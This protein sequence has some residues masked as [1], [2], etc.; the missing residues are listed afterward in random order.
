MKNFGR[1]LL[2]LTL[3]LV[4]MSQAAMAQD[5]RSVILPAPYTSRVGTQLMYVY[6]DGVNLGARG[7]FKTFM[8]IVNTNITTGVYVH[9]QF[10]T[11]NQ[12]TTGCVE[13]FDFVDY[14]TP[15]QRHIFDPR[16]VKGTWDLSTQV[17]VATDGRFVMTATPISVGRAWA[18]SPAD[19]RAVAFNHLSGQLWVSDVKKQA[20]YMTNAISRMAVDSLGTPLPTVAGGIILNGEANW[21]QM[22]RP[23]ILSVN[24]FFR[25]QGANAVQA[26]VPFGNRMTLFAWSD[27]YTNAQQMYRILTARVT[28][29]AFVFDDAEN[30][31]SVPPR[32][33]NCVYDYV[34]APDVAGASG[35][36]PDFLGAALTSAVANTGGWLRMRTVLGDTHNIV[37][38]FSQYLG[39]FGGGDYL[40]GE[41]RTP[42]KVD[43]AKTPSPI[44]GFLTINTSTGD[45]SGTSY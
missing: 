45:V 8:T 33:I 29:N 12:S 1:A 15:G 4:L 37:G 30:A 22:F 20:T 10:Y 13:L 35:N 31:F 27:Q 3:G 21:L 19:L 16:A 40:I 11:V 24:S 28:L 34:I 6:E 36:W 25:T 9:Y 14:L 17:G 5:A 44:S 39:T 41:G 26:G 18:P 42:V 32:E 43:P 7:E 38:W 23:I 2:L